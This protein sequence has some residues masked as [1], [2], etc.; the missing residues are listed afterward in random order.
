MKKAN[1]EDF[2]RSKNENEHKKIDGSKWPQK[3]ILSYKVV[4][5]LEEV[6]EKYK[7]IGQIQVIFQ[8]STTSQQFPF[9]IQSKLEYIEK[10]KNHNLPI[11][12]FFACFKQFTIETCRICSSVGQAKVWL[13]WSYEIQSLVGLKEVNQK[14]VSC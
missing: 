6:I 9:Q 2:D 11:L 1:A 8:T 5:A 13:S 10:P 12:T 3:W 14:I 7:N 4:L